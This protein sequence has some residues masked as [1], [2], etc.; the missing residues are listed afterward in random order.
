MSDPAD[1]YA[2]HPPAWRWTHIALPSSDIERSIDALKD[3]ASAREQL[4]FL[5]LIGPSGSGK[6]SLARAG[7]LPRLTAPGA[8]DLF[9]DLLRRSSQERAKSGSSQTI[10]I[11]SGTTEH[12]ANGS[13]DRSLHAAVSRVH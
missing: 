1:K 4:A 8:A 3:V 2:V 10:S 6:S 11:K 13:F 9:I 7:L 5:L 12:P